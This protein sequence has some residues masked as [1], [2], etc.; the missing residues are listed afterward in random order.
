MFAPPRYEIYTKMTKKIL[1]SI[2][3]VANLYLFSH[4]KQPPYLLHRMFKT[5]VLTNNIK[6]NTTMFLSMGFMKLATKTTEQ[7]T[8]HHGVLSSIDYY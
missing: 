4:Q 7:A 1:I 8:Y 5:Y 2:Y 3:N 6:V